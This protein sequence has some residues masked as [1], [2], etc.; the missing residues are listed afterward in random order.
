MQDG[1]LRLQGMWYLASYHALGKGHSPQQRDHTEWDAG[2]HSNRTQTQEG[3]L[4]QRERVTLPFKS[5][6]NKKLSSECSQSSV[7]TA[8]ARLFHGTEAA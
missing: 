6:G 3:G 2:L 1:L 4:S 7:Y 5:N 8:G